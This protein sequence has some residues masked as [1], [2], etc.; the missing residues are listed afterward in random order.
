[1]LCIPKSNADK[2]KKAIQ[3]GEFSIARLYTM[4]SDERH[5]IFSEYLQDKMATFV[6]GEFEKVM[7]SKQK[8]ALEKWVTKTFSRESAPKEEVL[9][10]IEDMKDLMNPEEG[11]DFFKDLVASKM[12]VTLSRDEAKTIIEKAKNLESL[13]GQKTELGLPSLE[14]L[15]A[16]NEMERYIQGLNPT[17]NSRILTSL[18]GRAMMLF[19]PSSI[20][21]NLEGNTLNAILKTLDKKIGYVSTEGHFKGANSDLIK[22]FVNENVKNYYETGMDFTR[23]NTLSEGRQILT[24]D[25]IHSEGKGIVRQ[26]LGKPAEKYL[27]VSQGLPDV[28][29][30]SNIFADT[31]NIMSTAVARREGHEGEAL[32]VRA[33]ELMKDAMKMVPETK[34][35]QSIRDQAQSDAQNGTYTDSSV[36][37][38]VSLGIRK[39]FNDILP[40]ARL[41]DLNIPFAKTPANVVSQ[42]IETAGG[43]FVEV[44]HQ[45]Y[46]FKKAW[47]D[48]GRGSAEARAHLNKT[49]RILV[50]MGL[51][52]IL[53]AL[54]ASNVDPEDFIGV[55]PTTEKERQ[56]LTLRNG[57]ANS[58]RIGDK[59]VSVEYLGPLAPIVT[60]ILYAKK[61]G[62]SDTGMNK[63]GRYLQGAGQGVLSIPG[64]K[65]ISDMINY[66]IDA[67]K[68][69]K[70]T[71]EML[72]E[73][74][75]TLID[76]VRGRSIPGI[77][78]DVAKISDQYERKTDSTA[79]SKAE[80][81]I[82]G[83]REKL[84][85]K[86]DVFGNKIETEPWWSVLFGG[87]RLK[88][89]KEN[90]VTKE[91][92]RLKS[93]GQLPSLT[94]V[95]KTSTRVKEFKTQ[96]SES[97]YKNTMRE[98]KSEYEKAI[99]QTIA[100]P[101]Y[102]KAD[103]EGKKKLLDGKKEDILDAALKKNGYKKPKKK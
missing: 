57:I 67:S 39:I 89:A 88:S 76:F 53:G 62:K 97:K 45:M 103:D 65:Q 38:K 10:K 29:F 100:S 69:G 71:S 102:H 4:T 80:A 22:Q 27:S 84:P 18:V 98:F 50:R 74:A 19:R 49:I 75:N 30:A 83:L 28:W 32:K 47:Q 26:Y 44:A 40:N 25:Q 93:K 95:E 61:Y 35:G 101:E 99:K 31:A 94:D 6:N 96:V 17:P 23:M 24:E 81:T 16:Y 87:S 12:G 2:L 85:A 48:F 36:A 66:L 20:V 59:W 46:E 41:G 63:V 21:M 54:I 56:L 8:D 5:A 15:K 3:E 73:T 13:S 58:V 1:M 42:G 77:V 14:Y 7:L 51:G 34:E 55:Y 79:I 91:L 52:G 70:T 68:E 33:R 37:A 60:G 9:S 86:T 43:G 78:S 72:N 64:V 11:N 82:P 92:I 90:A